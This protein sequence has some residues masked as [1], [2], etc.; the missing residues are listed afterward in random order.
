MTE[1]AQSRD[2]RSRE[3][4]LDATRSFIVQAPAGSGKTELLTQRYLVLLARVE[5]PE[6]IVS[7]TFTNKAA[8]EMRNRVL[9]ALNR[10][11]DAAPPETPHTRRTWELARAVLEQDTRRGWQL[12]ANPKR[13]R[14]RTIDALCAALARAMPLTA[15]FGAEPGVVE[16]AQA[17]YTEAAR[18]TM[19]LLESGQEWSSAVERLLRHLD[20]SLM[21]V[22]QLLARMLA[23]RDHWLRH[24]SGRGNPRLAR[25]TLEAALQHVVA[26]ELAALA[27]SVPTAEAER[28]V[29][30][31]DYAAANLQRMD[32]SAPACVC[33][34][35]TGLPGQSP[36]DLALWRG[37]A[38]LLLTKDG[39]WRTKIDKGCGF[40]APGSAKNKDEA[41]RF[42]QTKEAMG[43]LL[44]RLAGHGNFRIRLH[45]LR[46][47][48][49]IAY[50]EDQ[51]QVLDA[52]TVLLPLAAAQLNL[53]F[54]NHGQVDFV[55][56]THG[57]LDALGTSEEPTDL[58]LALDYRIRHILIDEFQDTSFSQYDLLERLTAGWEPGDGRT[59]FAVGDPMQS[60]YR[61]REAEVGL[62]LRARQEGLGGIRLEPLTLSVNFRSQGGIVDWVNFAFAHV[63]PASDDMTFGA[64]SYAAAIAHHP[65]AV[66]SA[67]TVH[68]Q[69]DDSAERE[70]KNI[71]ALVQA[72]RDRDSQASVAIL[73]RARGHLN[74]ILPELKQA[75]IPFLAL[76]IEPLGHRPVV[77]DLLALVRALEHP[78]DRTAW[79]AVLRAPWC[80]LT[81]AD[82]HALCADDDEAAIWDLM[83]DE[84]RQAR[85]S[86]DGQARLM[87]VRQV[88]GECLAQRRRQPLRRAVEGAWSALGGPGCVVQAADL[89][90]ADIFLALL[91]ELEEGGELRSVRTLEQ[92]MAKL[93]ALPAATGAPNP[94]QVMT[95]HKAKGLEFDT[96]IVPG[97]AKSPRRSDKQLLLWA[98]R[99][100]PH[101]A[102]D[103][104]LAPVRASGTDEDPT[105]RYLQW[106]EQER[107]RHE[108]GRLLYVAATRARKQLHLLGQ[109]N[110]DD[111]GVVGEPVAGSLLKA[112]WPAAAGEFQRA[113]ADERGD[114]KNEGPSA[115][116]LRAAQGIQRL[117]AGWQ[118]PPVPAS[119]L[120]AV[121]QV[122]E[123]ED[124]EQLEYDWVRETARHVG[125]VVHRWLLR[126]G[127]E[128]LERW[129]P[130][131]IAAHESA[132]RL[133]LA[134]LGVP[135]QELPAA[136]ERVCAALT[137]ALEDAQ[138]RWLLDAHP[139][140][141][142][143][144]A[145]TGVLD[146]RIV[147]VVLDRTFVDNDG[148]RWIV[149]Y[150]TSTH[151]GSDRDAFLDRERSRYTAQLERYAR[152]LAQK[153]SRPVRLGLYFPLLRG[154]RELS[155]G[156]G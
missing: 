28:I 155:L 33:A 40:P 129:K 69:F 45:A 49:H 79:L 18:A 121:I 32:A 23:R 146:G 120:G 82:L 140:A 98:E 106:L 12:A 5:H 156:E 58:A 125:T 20:N 116:D 87:R 93:Y 62:Y 152:L 7:I 80:G 114:G 9:T 99:P 30:L 83:N 117:R 76:E 119:P 15:G 70:A 19:A 126:I 71:V 65:T 123:P 10:A 142:S 91:E 111:N 78:A 36:S 139:E 88:L 67:V 2:S 75:R 54:R 135:V 84:V 1:S 47:L 6:E 109:V 124:I 44:K 92:R 132:F 144:Y 50:A 101:G 34:G 72:A 89:E 108:D 97:L 95:I 148:V 137:N 56:V 154:W 128:G 11:R 31:A 68:P 102:A 145:L 3:R 21:E 27:A 73:V 134:H 26:E 74:A 57:A 150:K 153:E 43:E 127:D 113:A 143:E 38:S 17:L 138:A 39:K 122:P 37:I 96:V 66:G 61:F 131:H 13:L 24:V 22:E 63:F 147:N 85:L 51:W 4:A 94:V 42:T 35:L 141:R 14:V 16:D 81:L 90:D 133:A 151:E 48:P 53:V 55:A 103:L 100:R 107:A 52:L 64:V 59:L 41:Q 112:L 149:D 130:T 46:Q 25:E 29:T 8:G 110:R 60:I 104:L 77:Q 86:L 115:I 118:L 105:Y 136:V